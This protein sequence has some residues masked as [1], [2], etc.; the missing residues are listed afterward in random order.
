VR[1]DERRAQ[2]EETVEAERR[3]KAEREAARVAVGQL[4][5]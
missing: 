1:A 2:R 3:Q 4:R 5:S